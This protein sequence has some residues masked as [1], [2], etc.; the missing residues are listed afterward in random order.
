M[1]KKI[2]NIVKEI[3]NAPKRELNY[4]FQK[5]ISY[6]QYSMWKKCPKQWAL[7]YRDGYKR[8]IPSIYTVFGTAFHETLQYYIEI[9]YDVSG[10]EADRKDLNGMLKDKLRE[11]Y[12]AEYKKNNSQHF[13]TPGELEEFYNDGVKILQFI[14]KRKGEFYTKRGWY[15]VG[16][17][18]PILS[19]PNPEYPNVLYMG[20]LDVVFYHEPTNT[21]K[22]I[23]IKT[24]TRG[25]NDFQKKDE[26]KQFQL[27]LY[28]KY[29]GE[30]FNIPKEN[31]EI[32]F[33]I[34]KR[35]IY[36]N[37]EFPQRRTQEFSP[38]SGKI[39]TSRAV[40]SINNFLEDCFIKTQGKQEYSTKE[41]LPY[42]SKN[43][44][45]FCNYKKDKELCGLGA[46]L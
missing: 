13:T 19:S 43:S 29:F 36:E 11:H 34:V 41:M 14:K 21:F 6:S 8:Y 24:S 32:E 15:L 26:E 30:Q 46:C 42:A 17:E 7:H 28:K 20:Y 40:K 38:P 37:S 18:T 9:T 3:K 10:A 27:I 22:I 39:K 44:C 31:I 2:P 4:S 33:F 45:F 5:N 23:D 16:I 25:W 35:K 12:Q 1:K